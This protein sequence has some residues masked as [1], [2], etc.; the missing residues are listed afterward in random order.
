MDRVRNLGF[1][2]KDVSRLWVRY[3]ESLADQIGMTLTQAKV[4]VFLSRN[5]GTTQVGLAD[6]CDTDP[7][8]LVR[9]LDRMEREGLLERRVDPNDRRVYRVFLRPA[10]SPIIA[11]ITRIGDKARGEALSGLSNDERTQLVSLLERVH[12]NLVALVPAA[13][14]PRRGNGVFSNRPVRGRRA[15]HGNPQR[16]RKTSP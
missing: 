15:P 4:L 2:M 13:S 12:G 10:A 5:E 7:M 6:L 3:F 11:E 1:I 9:V 14:E 8:T 16:R